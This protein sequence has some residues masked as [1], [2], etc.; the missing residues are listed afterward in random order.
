MFEFGDGGCAG[1][2]QVDA[3]G[4][5][6]NGFGQKTRV[7]GRAATNKSQTRSRRGRQ[8]V[9][10]SR[11]LGSVLGLGLGLPFGK[12][13]SSRGVGTAA[14]WSKE[15]VVVVVVRVM[16]MMVVV[17]MWQLIMLPSMQAD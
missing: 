9:E 14:L 1:L 11:E 17:M 5:V 4:A 8:V 6:G 12:V 15:K 10:G 16:M 2:F 3:L 7:V 13:L